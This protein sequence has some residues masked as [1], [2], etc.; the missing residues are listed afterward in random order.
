MSTFGACWLFAEL[1]LVSFRLII[2][3]VTLGPR[4]G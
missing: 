3:L 2:W 1:W 4:E